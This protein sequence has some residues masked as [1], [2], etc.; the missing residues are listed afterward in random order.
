MNKRRLLKKFTLVELVVSLGIFMVVSGIIALASRTFYDSYSRSLRVTGRLKEYMAI[1]ALMD[2][3]V[4][5]LI[6]F[7]WNDENGNKRFV[8]SIV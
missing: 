1:D 4:R 2:V 6:P 5:N 8:F 3:Q 7:E